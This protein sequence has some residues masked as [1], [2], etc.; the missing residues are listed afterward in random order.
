MKT[1]NNGEE[2]MA[3]MEAMYGPPQ[4]FQP[5]ATYIRSGDCI[6]FV[7]RPGRYRAQRLD[8][9]VTVYLSEENDEVVGSLIKGVRQLCRQ[10]TERLPGFKVNVDDGKVR[11]EYL[12][13]AHLWSEPQSDKLIELTY[14]KLLKVAVE[15]QAEAELC[16]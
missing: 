11:L 14:R 12:F 3:E 13:L 2:F 8:E 5:T 16:V 4:E 10:I 6:E 7:A 9:L 15:T 1:L